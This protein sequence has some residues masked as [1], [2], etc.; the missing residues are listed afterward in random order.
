M[1]P[2]RAGSGARPLPA[3]PPPWHAQ[4]TR[5]GDTQE[6]MLLLA[7]PGRA[8]RRGQH[9]PALDQI[10]AWYCL[11]Q[12]QL[13]TWDGDNLTIPPLQSIAVHVGGERLRLSAVGRDW[14]QPATSRSGDWDAEWVAAHNMHTLLGVL[15]IGPRPP[16]APPTF[17]DYFVALRGGDALIGDVPVLCDGGPNV[18]PR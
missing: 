5:W 6:P 8:Y 7:G 16:A 9:V 1:E 2:T 14:L 3:D 18:W 13:A 10:D 12:L 15:F 17:Q 4:W 11:D